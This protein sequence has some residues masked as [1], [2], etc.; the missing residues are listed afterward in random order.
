[1]NIINKSNLLRLI[2]FFLTATVMCCTFGFTTDGWKIKKTNDPQ[3]QSNITASPEH[4]EEERENDSAPEDEIIVEPI[5]INPL[6]GEEDTEEA[7]TSFPLSFVID[8]NSPAY[9]VSNAD[10]LIDFPTENNNSRYLCITT[11]YTDIW[12]IG[13]LSP[14]RGYITNLASFFGADIISYG[15]D[16]LADYDSCNFINKSIDISLESAKY[17][18]EY[19][20]Y[21]F[22]C[23]DLFLNEQELLPASLEDE[24]VFPFEFISYDDEPIS[25]EKEVTRV[26]IK[27]SVTTLTE[28][29]FDESTGNYKIS[30]NGSSVREASNGEIQLFENCLVLFADS[31]TYDLSSYN[32]TVVH[33]LGTGTGFY[34]TEGTAE[35]I[36]WTSDSDGNMRINDIE[37]NLLTFNTGR[38]YI[39]YLKAS[40]K[41]NIHFS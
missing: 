28:L 32:Q 34:F 23:S 14:T 18:T 29:V 15:K 11:K 22:T 31:V 10:V 36:I 17:Y 9:G 19:G 13:S 35:E 38:T 39:K 25:F 12:K 24:R 37:G 40:Q 3:D 1:M 26:M 6:T 16:D 2:A 5:Y 20:K 27:E 41:E 30:K 21:I 7:A 4:K 8:G 33:T